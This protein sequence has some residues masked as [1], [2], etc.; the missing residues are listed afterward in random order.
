MLFRSFLAVAVAHRADLPPELLDKLIRQATATV[1]DRLVTNAPAELRDRIAEVVSNVS[2]QVARWVGPAA[3]RASGAA[4]L[5]PSRLRARIAQC[6]E[7]K[8]L[9]QLVSS[10]A[11]LA[12]VPARTIWDLIRQES[13][14]GLMILGK[15]CG[16]GWP[17]MHKVLSAAVPV[18]ARTPDGT[19]ELF[20]KFTDL[21]VAN[22]QRAVR[23][24][25]T[26][27]SRSRDEYRL[28]A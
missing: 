7:E 20:D 21:S 12:E 5:D 14:E 24:I 22:A 26:N 28:S 9:E 8:N 2:G 19:N 11:A 27:S 18:Q 10:F 3:A 13:N 1:R 15:A 17:D 23:F 6:A 16:L 4:R 25:R